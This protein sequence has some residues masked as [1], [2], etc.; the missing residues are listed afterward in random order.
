MANFLEGDLEL[1]ASYEGDLRALETEKRAKLAEIARMRRQVETSFRERKT[2]LQILYEEKAWAKKARRTANFSKAELAVQPQKHGH[3]RTFD[4]QI[5]GIPRTKPPDNLIVQEAPIQLPREE[6]SSSSD[7]PSSAGFRAED[8]EAPR[9]SAPREAAAE[10]V[11]S[12]YTTFK[13]LYPSNRF[14]EAKAKSSFE[15]KTKA[16]RQLV[17]QRLRVYLGSERWVRSLAEDNGRW[18]PFASNWVKAYCA[19]PPPYFQARVNEHGEDLGQMAAMTRVLQRRGA[20][21]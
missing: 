20:A 3:T 13:S 9:S 19:D 15:A 2:Q 14:D 6:S 10:G 16:E 17:I 7:L 5:G 18:I 4:P 21:S 1:S 11:D 12:D 8:D